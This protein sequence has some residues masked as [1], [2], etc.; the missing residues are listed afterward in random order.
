[1]GDAVF[2]VF[3]EAEHRSGAVGDGDNAASLVGAQEPARRCAAAFVPGDWIVDA[4]TVNVSP[5]HRVGGVIFGDAVE[6]VVAHAGGRGALGDLVQPPHRIVVQGRAARS[7]DEEVFA[8]VAVVVG[9]DRGDVAARVVG[10]GLGADIGD[11]VEAVGGGGVVLVEV[12]GPG[13]KVVGAGDAADLAGGIIGER[14]GEVIGSAGEVG[15]LG[16]EAVRG[17]GAP[18]SARA[19]PAAR[20]ARR[21]GQ[22]VGELRD[23][24]NTPLFRH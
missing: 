5:Y 7:R 6:A 14:L 23:L 11:L 15:G 17:D 4:G 9:A 3:V 13:V 2:V 8:G 19:W 12:A 16:G 24:S 10:E 1:M 18:Q 22:G 21:L 20:R